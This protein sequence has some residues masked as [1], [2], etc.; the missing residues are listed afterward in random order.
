MVSVDPYPIRASTCCSAAIPIGCK[1]E[2]TC[3]TVLTKKKKVKIYQCVKCLN[4]SNRKMCET[5]KTRN[6]MDLGYSWE[7]Y[8]KS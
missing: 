2:D 3:F 7:E 1:W 8:G 6:Y 4:V 5:C